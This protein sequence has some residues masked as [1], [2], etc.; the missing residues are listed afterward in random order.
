M[1]KKICNA[2]LKNIWLQLLALILA[3]CGLT[4]LIGASF[5]NVSTTSKGFSPSSPDP[6]ASSSEESHESSKD[7]FDDFLNGSGAFGD[8]ENFSSF[9]VETEPVTLQKDYMFTVTRLSSVARQVVPPATRLEHMLYPWVYFAVLPLF[10]L[11]NA[12]VSFLGG[13]VL[14]MVSSPVFFGVFFGLLLGKPI[15]IL[16]FSFLTVTLKIANLPDHV[17]WIHMLGAGILGG[18][19][20]TMAIFVA[21]LAF[22]E[23]VLIADAKIG[24]L[25]ASLL[26]GVIGFLFLQLD[27]ARYNII[28]FYMLGVLLTAL[29]TS[30]Y[31]CGVLG[32]IAS[33]AL[34][35]FFLTEPRLTFHAYDPGYQITFVLML[36][37]AIV[38]CTLTTRLKDQAKMSAQ[39]AFRTKVLFD[40]SRLLQ[41]ATNEDEILSL[42]AAQLTKLL[43]RN[44]IVYPEQDGSLGQGQIFNTVEES[45][46]LRFDSAPERSAAE[47]CFANKK[48]S[49]ASTDYCTDAKGLYLAIRTGSG[50]FGVIG[51]DLSERSMDAFENSVLLSILGECALAVENRRIALEKEQATV[52]AQ[53]EQLRANLLRTISHDL[54]TP[55]TSISGNA[56]NLLSNAETLDAETRTKICTDIFDDAQWLIG[57]VE[58]LLSITRIED[59]R[60]NLQISPQLM[61]EVVE[62]TLRHISRKSKEHIITTTYSDEILLADMDARLI[63]Q[64]IINLVDNAIKYTQKGSRINISAYAKNSNIVVEVSD[65]GPGIPEQNKAQVFEMFFTGQNQI[66]DS[67]RSLGLGL[68]LCR[69]ILAA[70]KGTLTLRDN[71]PHG[72]IFSFELPKSEVSI[73]E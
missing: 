56:S 32:S 6:D 9:Y 7:D 22:P 16:L 4:L 48:R 35:N 69:T 42:T 59:G 62:E 21:N 5:E 26:A 67:H 36:T 13:D 10:A 44:L 57:L 51:I 33:V 38:T 65:D 11:T 70:H 66:A 39:A 1:F 72:C 18:M 55:L 52:H 24:I 54:R 60:M 25:S 15:G 28:M 12:D 29:T 58:N 45:S 31:S 37:S 34:Y 73:H 23:A 2:V 14:A 46:R 53:N 43:N 50:V 30:G 27:F 61:D 8:W 47:W 17:N 20:F 68:A 40:T 63:M 49:G 3:L 19:G 71:E 41:K 64:V